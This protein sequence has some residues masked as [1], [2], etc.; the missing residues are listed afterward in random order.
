MKKECLKKKI[1]FGRFCTCVFGF[2]CFSLAKSHVEA[3]NSQNRGPKQCS[4]QLVPLFPIGQH[5]PLPR[6]SNP[7]S[8]RDWGLHAMLLCRRQAPC[9]LALA[10]WIKT[11]AI[12]TC[13]T[14]YSAKHQRSTAGKILSTQQ[15]AALSFCPKRSARLLTTWSQASINGRQST[16][17]DKCLT[18]K[19]AAA[20]GGVLQFQ[21][22]KV[23]HELTAAETC[24]P[25]TSAH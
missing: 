4:R 8:V 20:A 13:E 9:M 5:S 12:G 6:P 17:A 1:R 22:Q 11:S 25:P 7:V 24:L 23:Q 19:A 14:F 15:L 21:L 3:S 16:M 10:A 2:R 18:M